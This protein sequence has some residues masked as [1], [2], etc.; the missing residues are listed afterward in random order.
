MQWFVRLSL[1]RTLLEPGPSASKPELYKVRFCPLVISSLVQSI[2]YD[3]FHVVSL[4]ANDFLGHLKLFIILYLNIVSA[5]KLARSHI[6]AGDFDLF[7]IAFLE[8]HT[9]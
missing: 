9:T 4:R 8:H 7:L 3:L 1:C 6:V 5:S 2:V